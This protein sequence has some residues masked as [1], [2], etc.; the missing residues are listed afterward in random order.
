M[1]GLTADDLLAP[2]HGLAAPRD[3]GGLLS[4]LRVEREPGYALASEE[5][6]I[7]L[8]SLGIPLRDQAGELLAVVYVSRP[9]SRLIGCVDEIV[10]R[11]RAAAG[12]TPGGPPRPPTVSGD[13]RLGLS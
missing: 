13:R 4:R 2:T 11:L 12:L 10:H 3:L 8:T 6:E 7:G 5:A 1:E 9:T